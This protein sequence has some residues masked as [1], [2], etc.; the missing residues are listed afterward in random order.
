M[1]TNVKKALM[2]VMIHM[3]YVKTLTGH[4]TA[5][6]V[7]KDIWQMN[8]TLNVLVS[9]SIVECIPLYY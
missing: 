9:E 7:R 5:F 1:L 8:T 3:K 4:L 6:L 2:T